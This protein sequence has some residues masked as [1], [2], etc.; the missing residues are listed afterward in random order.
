MAQARQQH[1]GSAVLPV[2]SSNAD[3]NEA[4]PPTP[5]PRDKGRWRV[6]PAPDGRGLP[7]EH[8]PRPPHRWR[9]FWIVFAV[10]LAVNWL[11]VMMVRSGQPRVKVPFSPYFVQQVSAGR[12]A[13]I[14][15]R[16][17]TIEGT[18]K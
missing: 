2:A 16:G 10:L 14:S 9:S 17:D 11:S 1:D 6:A 4:V 3:T 13:S 15:S 8:K 5:L 7:D 18:F 12:V